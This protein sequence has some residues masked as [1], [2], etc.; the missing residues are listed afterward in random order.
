MGLSCGQK[1]YLCRRV[2]GLLL[3]IPGWSG[4]SFNTNRTHQG[5]LHH[6]TAPHTTLPAGTLLHHTIPQNQNGRKFGEDKKIIFLERNGYE[7]K[8]NK[9]GLLFLLPILASVVGHAEK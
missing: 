6:S 9:G 4:R 5:R 2:L 1:L 8:D 3:R 7:G